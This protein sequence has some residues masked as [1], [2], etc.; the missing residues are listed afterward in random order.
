MEAYSESSALNGRAAG[1][2]A[3]AA[4]LAALTSI[5]VILFSQ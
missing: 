2:S 4:F 3:V 1:W 5:S